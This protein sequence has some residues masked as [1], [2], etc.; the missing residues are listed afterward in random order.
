M[1][2]IADYV[3]NEGYISAGELNEFDTDLWRKA[4]KSFNNAK[5]LNDEIAILSK[6]LLRVA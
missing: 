2:Q 3:I 6:F 4:V 5:V 1:K